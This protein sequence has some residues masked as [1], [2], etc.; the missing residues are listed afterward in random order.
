[1]DWNGITTIISTIILPVLA[2][3]IKK[4]KDDQKELKLDL[5]KQLKEQK[6]LFETKTN[7]LKDQN[8]RLQSELKDKETG[9]REVIISHKAELTRETENAKREVRSDI[10]LYTKTLSDEI[11]KRRQADIDIYHDIDNVGDR[12]DSKVE[13]VN[14]KR[15]NDYKELKNELNKIAIEVSKITIKKG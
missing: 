9:L 7:S 11:E 6:E 12:F 3:V 5:E 13:K 4:S 8:V 14:D 1:M 10:T 15:E 2:W